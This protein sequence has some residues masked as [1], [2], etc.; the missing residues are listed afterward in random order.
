MVTRRLVPLVVAVAMALAPVALDACQ[1]M[2]AM[3]TVAAAAPQAHSC[4]HLA[5]PG[6]A[7]GTSQ[8]QGLPHRC[9]HADDLPTAAMLALQANLAAPAVLPAVAFDAAPARDTAGRIEPTP[10][11]TPPRTANIAQL[12]V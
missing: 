12:R 7:A 6:P 3:H 10:V 11:A 5:E 1:V 4:H 9:A 2:C 8:I